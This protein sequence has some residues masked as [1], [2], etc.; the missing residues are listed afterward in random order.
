MTESINKRDEQ[1]EIRIN[2]LKEN[3]RIPYQNLMAEINTEYNDNKL[4]FQRCD[5]IEKNINSGEQYLIKLENKINT[6]KCE[7]EAFESL[8]EE[9]DRLHESHD[10]GEDISSFPTD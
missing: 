7:S 8:L 4:L 3:L 9:A 1:I 5:E 6:L 10:W 2:E